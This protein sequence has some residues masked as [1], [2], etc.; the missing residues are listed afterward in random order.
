MIAVGTLPIIVCGLAFKDQIETTLRSLYVV[1]AA[2][3]GLAVLLGMV[4]LAVRRR[5]A[6]GEPG[7]GVDQVTWRDA[8]VVGFAQAAALIPGTSRSGSTIFGGLTCGLSREAAARYSFLLSIPAVFARR[9]VS[10][11]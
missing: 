10:I 1:S 11:V 8:I 9:C 3:V 2:L 6:A 5:I 4:E 7:R